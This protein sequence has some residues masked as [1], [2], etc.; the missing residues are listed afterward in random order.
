MYVNKKLCKYF[1]SPSIFKRCFQIKK[2]KSVNCEIIE[3]L[4]EMSF[5]LRE[6]LLSLRDFSPLHL[7]SIWNS[8]D[9][10]C[11]WMVSYYCFIS[12]F[13]F[14]LNSQKDWVKQYHKTKWLLDQTEKQSVTIIPRWRIIKY[15]PFVRHS[16]TDVTCLERDMKIYFR[17]QNVTE[18]TRQ[19]WEPLCQE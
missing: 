8:N 4:A 15:S 1:H 5:C 3:I 19:P 14:Q 11:T 9:K 16:K 12:H 7:I 18:D 6:C 2:R 10:R 13:T 17:C